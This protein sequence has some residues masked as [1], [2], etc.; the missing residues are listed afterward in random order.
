M[1]DW[2]K[3]FEQIGNGPNEELVNAL[4]AYNPNR[5]IALDLGAGNMRDSK[6]LV[7]QGFQ[8]VVAVDTSPLVLN[9]AVPGIEVQISDINQ[10]CAVPGTVDL[11]VSFNSLFFLPN[12]KLMELFLRVYQCMA[13]GAYFVFNALGPEDG[14]VKEGRKDVY[15]IPLEKLSLYVSPF[16]VVEANEVKGYG[17]TTR[18]REKFWHVWRVVLRR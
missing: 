4:S 7:S 10:F 6:F 8:R 2:G 18:G 14:W 17:K 13:P 5:S 12:K 9:Y 16:K 15:P 3:Y 11:V 1:S